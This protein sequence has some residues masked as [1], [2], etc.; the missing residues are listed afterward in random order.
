MILD[1]F[2]NISRYTPIVKNLENALDFINA[3]GKL[4]VGRYEFDGG[5]LMV[6][7]GITNPIEECDFETHIQYIDVQYVLEGSEILVWADKNDLKCTTQYDEK[8]DAAFYEGKGTIM[9]AKAGM[10]YI[11]FPRDAHKACCHVDMP[12]RYKKYV[13]KLPV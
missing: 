2:K 3:S 9:E 12:K 4:S 6:Q 1:E 10:I 7:D 5:F 8:K 11:M 13:I